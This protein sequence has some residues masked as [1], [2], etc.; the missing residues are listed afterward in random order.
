MRA[1]RYLRLGT[2]SKKE[3]FLLGEHDRKL[4]RTAGAGKVLVG[5]GHFERGEIEKPQ[6]GNAP[7]DRFGG[8]LA[9]VEQVELILADGLDVEFFRTLSEVVGEAGHAS[10]IVLLGAGCEIAQLHIVDHALT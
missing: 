3:H 1:A 7:I 8:E 6:G 2:W 4:V 10:D 5:P 9:F